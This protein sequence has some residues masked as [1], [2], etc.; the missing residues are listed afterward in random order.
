MVD[1]VFVRTRGYATFSISAYSA[2][3]QT[4][5]VCT[6]A[7]CNVLKCVYRF[8][9]GFSGVY[10][11]SLRWE[12]IES[13]VLNRVLALPNRGP[14]QERLGHGSLKTWLPSL[15]TFMSIIKFRMLVGGSSQMFTQ[16]M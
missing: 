6:Y 8:V 3:A 16:F 11:P 2:C 5:S 13:I 12:N 7:C 4:L 9:S 15:N 14:I 10:S 1:T